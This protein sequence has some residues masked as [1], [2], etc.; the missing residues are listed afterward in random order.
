MCVCVHVCVCTHD[1]EMHRLYIAFVQMK[2]AISGSFGL[3]F[4]GGTT[5]QIL[6]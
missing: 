1:L 4:E 2:L 3:K 5:L 6:F